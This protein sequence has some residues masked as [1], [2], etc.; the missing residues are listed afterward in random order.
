M[1]LP[2]GCF[3]VPAGKIA[4]VVTHLEMTDRPALGLDPPGAWSLRRAETPDLGW[5]RNLYRRIGEE[6][7]WFSRLQISDTE[8]AAIVRSPLVEVY[9]LVHE[10]SMKAC[11]NWTSASQGNAN[12]FSS[13]SPRS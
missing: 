13:A 10:A 12:W 2:D 6:W 7:L 3:D 4:A 8:L 5:F 11:L 9:A 1:I